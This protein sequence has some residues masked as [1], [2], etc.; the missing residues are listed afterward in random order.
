MR[1]QRKLSWLKVIHSQ[2][3]GGTGPPG[4]VVGDARD[5]VIHDGL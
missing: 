2:I 3:E 1:L 4:L 5:I